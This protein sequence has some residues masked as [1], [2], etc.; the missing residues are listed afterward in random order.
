[1]KL[2][3]DDRFSFN[4]D[5][6]IAPFKLGQLRFLAISYKPFV[7]LTLNIEMIAIQYTGFMDQI[8][9]L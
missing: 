1:M 7:A 3:Y 8:T 2:G 6:E 9:L 4:D 5:D